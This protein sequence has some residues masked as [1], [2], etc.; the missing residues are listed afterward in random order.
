[1]ENDLDKAID[2]AGHSRHNIFILFVSS[3]IHLAAVLDLLG[4]C[5]TVPAA[6]CDLQLGLLEISL[7]T[8]VPFAGY[9]SALPWGY[10]ADTH[11]RRKAILV[12]ATIGSTI[13]V[14]TSF[15]PSFQVMLI[16]KLIGCSFSTA[17]IT[18]TITYLGECTSSAYRN[19]YIF[20]MNSFNLASDFICY[21]LAY[22]ILRQDFKVDIPFLSI[23]YRPWRLFALVMALMLAFG[24]LMMFF[25][26]ESPKFLANKGRIDEAFQ[27]MKTAYG[28]SGTD[29]DLVLKSLIAAEKKQ[30][31]THMT[32]WNSVVEQTVPIFRP[33]LV[34]R[35]IQ[36]F[37]LMSV[38]S[39]TNN[40]FFM[41]FPTMVNSFYSSLSDTQSSFC[42]KVVTNLTNS[43]VS[44]NDTCDDTISNN[45]IYSGMAFSTFFT[46]V[47][48]A[49]SRLATRRKIVLMTTLVISGLSAVLVDLVYQPIVSMMFFIM[50]Q[51][52]GI[53]VGNVASYFVDLYPT[54]YRGLGTSLGLMCAR[55]TCLTGV[56]IVGAT[57]V[58]HCKMTFFGWAIFVFCGVAV[59]W[60][61]PSDKKKQLPT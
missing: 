14:I 22:I 50:I 6:S 38:C 31:R 28:V 15:S 5:V 35:T 11:G 42:E 49:S 45:T 46:V 4:Y 33:P 58:N 1:M 36:L 2:L 10:Y 59:A 13:A 24:A 8:S 32:F 51:L 21:A 20:I 17:S 60:F 40:V 3:F 37:F 47:N 26:H 48:Y 55:I 29:E 30:I 19:K 56:N 18:I 9:L 41:W 16:L 34:L 52:S 54:S 25:L 53:L 43:D 12:S 27:V 61:L 23:T 7:L 44:L 39:S 57:I